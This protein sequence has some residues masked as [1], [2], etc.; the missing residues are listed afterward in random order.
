MAVNDDI[1][2]AALESIPCDRDGLLRALIERLDD[3]MIHQIA[4]ADYKQDVAEHEAAIRE[5]CRTAGVGF[6]LR[7]HPHEVLAL[8]RWSTPE[9]RNWATG[10]P[11]VRNHIMRAFCCSILL[12]HPDYG[13]GDARE[14]IAPLIESA[15]EIGDK[16]PHQSLAFLNWCLHETAV[17][18][19]N[20]L[21]ELLAVLILYV[22]VS[23]N[24]D[25]NT[26]QQL[27][28]WIELEETSIR[29]AG[30]SWGNR[31]FWD[32]AHM[33]QRDPIWLKLIDAFLV[34]QKALEGNAAGADV[35]AFGRKLVEEHGK[36]RR[37]RE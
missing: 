17:D 28:Y 25:P 37:V 1:L 29:S 31:W 9:D 33:G 22:S 24:P 3:S 19:E 27:M 10:A 6:D 16:A 14:S 34:N 12:L 30:L 35:Q 18:E 8:V 5:I 20:R 13:A 15:F 36:K 11:G 2:R 7:W 4:E 21:F 32:I 23:D 26:I